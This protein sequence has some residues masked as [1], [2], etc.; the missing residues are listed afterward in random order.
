[1]IRFSE[2]FDGPIAR[3]RR[4][5]NSSKSQPGRYSLTV[6]IK[7]PDNRRAERETTLSVAEK[8]EQR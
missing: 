6:R 8:K 3:I 4:E 1:V 7:T 2:R 5:L